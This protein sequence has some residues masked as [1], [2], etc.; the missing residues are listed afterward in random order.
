MDE[1]KLLIFLNWT[2]RDAD[3]ATKRQID[4]YASDAVASLVEYVRSV[5]DARTDGGWNFS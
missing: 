4:G 1:F 3:T 2:Q 5:G